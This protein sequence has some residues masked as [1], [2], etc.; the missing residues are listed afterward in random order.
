MVNSRPSGPVVGFGTRS[1]G[2][3]R[4]AQA[5]AGCA[6]AALRLRPVGRCSVFDMTALADEKI[7]DHTTPLRYQT[8]QWE[9]HLE[10]GVS[11]GK[12]PIS[13]VHFPAGHV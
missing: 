6:F 11:I 10:I 8:W 7:G 13:M 1:R 4:A 12:S 3:R 9:I 5:V 2:H